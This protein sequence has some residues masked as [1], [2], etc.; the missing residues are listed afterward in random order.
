MDAQVGRVLFYE[1]VEIYVYEKGIS[2]HV[3]GHMFSCKN[4]HRSPIN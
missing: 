2:G 1:M 3:E 4:V